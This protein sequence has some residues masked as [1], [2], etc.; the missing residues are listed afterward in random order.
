MLMIG[1]CLLFVTCGFVLPVQAHNIIGKFARAEI[2]HQIFNT[3]ARVLHFDNLN[4]PSR[5]AGH[6]CRLN[7]VK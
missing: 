4:G 3:L 2:H 6:Y 1:W 5:K 7:L